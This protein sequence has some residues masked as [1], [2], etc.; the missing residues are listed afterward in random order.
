MRTVIIISRCLDDRMGKTNFHF[1]GFYAG[2]EI[3]ALQL[4]GLTSGPWKRNE[5]YVMYVQVLRVEA[6]TLYG[7]V[8]RSRLLLELKD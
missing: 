6:G 4:T 7:E 1:K 2:E 8:L 5:E 3:R